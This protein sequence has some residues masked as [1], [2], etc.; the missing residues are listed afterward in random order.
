MKARKGQLSYPLLLWVAALLVGGLLIPSGPASATTLDC[1]AGC[2]ALFGTQ[3]ARFTTGEIQPAGTGIFDT[4]VQMSHNGTE[5]AYNTT[6]DNVLDNKSSDN[7]NHAITLSQVPI[8]T[9]NGIKYR[10]FS[11]DI[12]QLNTATGKLLSLDGL[13]II[14]STTANQS[15]TPLPSGTVVYNLD[16]GGDN[17]IKLNANLFPPGSGTSDLFALIPNSLFTGPST[18][19]VYL[20]SQ[21]GLQ[22][23]AP[24]PAA[25][26]CCGSNDGFEEWRVQK[27]AAPPAVPEP[28]SLLLMGSGLVGLGLW[29]RKR[30]K[31][32]QA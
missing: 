7:F 4:F 18:Q 1:T 10:E 22:S 21:F 6:V 27:I 25:Q 20:W 5:Q 14:L 26:R 16:A 28:A 3:S 11:L 23:V 2:S 24:V 31:D 13:K 19:F 30:R 17:W 9:V 12:N 32:V 8:K 29:A 15:A